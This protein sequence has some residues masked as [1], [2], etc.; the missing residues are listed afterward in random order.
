[1]EEAARFHVWHE[2]LGAPRQPDRAAVEALDRGRGFCVVGDAGSGKTSTL[3][4]AAL[5]TDDFSVRRI[6]L[7]LSITGSEAAQ[8]A[9]D[10]RYLAGQLVR[11]MAL[12][13]AEAEDL[14]DDAAATGQASSA[15]VTWRAQAGL[16]LSGYRARFASARRTSTSSAPRRRSSTS[17]RTQ[18]AL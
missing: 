4:A 5:G 15:A 9:N 14:V 6:P 18:R 1:M 16:E 7:R 13:S 3:A 8:K 2:R 17:L 12:V 11:V 10:V